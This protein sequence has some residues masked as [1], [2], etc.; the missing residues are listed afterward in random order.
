MTAMHPLR[1]RMVENMQ[2]AGLRPNT[3]ESYAG[4][5]S[6]LARHCGRSP[7]RL[8]EEDVRAFFLHEINDRKLAPNTVRTHIYGIRFFYDLNSR[9]CNYA[10]NSMPKTSM[11]CR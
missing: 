6:L 4:A 9:K 7:K 3:Q 2:L 10:G 8:G 1:Q 5:V 11:I